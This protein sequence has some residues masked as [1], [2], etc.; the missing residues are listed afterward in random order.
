MKLYKILQEFY[1]SKLKLSKDDIKNKKNEKIRDKLLV[2]R[3][4]LKNTYT[5]IKKDTNKSNDFYKNEILSEIEDEIKVIDKLLK[6]IDKKKK[7]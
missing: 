1:E 2:K 3:D 5:Q 4:I 6:K 7:K